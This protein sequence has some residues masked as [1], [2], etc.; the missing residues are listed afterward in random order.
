M[1]ISNFFVIHKGK[2]QTATLE[3]VT[4]NTHGLSKLAQ[5]LH[6]QVNKFKI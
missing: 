3:E 5:D 6:N 2:E 4:A 1:F